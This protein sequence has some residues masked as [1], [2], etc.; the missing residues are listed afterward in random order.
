MWKEEKSFSRRIEGIWMKIDFYELYTLFFLQEYIF[1]KN[2][3][4]EISP[5]VKNIVILNFS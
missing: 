4:H 3:Q 5:K 1:Y 2:I